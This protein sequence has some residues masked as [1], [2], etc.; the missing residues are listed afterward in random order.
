MKKGKFHIVDTPI[1][2]LSVYIYNLDGNSCKGFTK[3]SVTG[4]ITK[5]SFTKPQII[6]KNINTSNCGMVSFRAKIRVIPNVSY[7]CALICTIKY[8]CYEYSLTNNKNHLNCVEFS[9]DNIFCIE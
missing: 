5:Q 7:E 3:K 9:N 4:T 1:F 8:I 6:L 2:C